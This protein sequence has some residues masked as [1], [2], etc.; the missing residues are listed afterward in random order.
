MFTTLAAAPL[1][2]WALA[3]VLGSGRRRGRR[4][5]RS[6]ARAFEY[7]TVGAGESL[8]AIAESIAPDAD[9]RES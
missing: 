2:V 1:V 3:M 8:W 7:V 5:S 4:P 6:A 9:P